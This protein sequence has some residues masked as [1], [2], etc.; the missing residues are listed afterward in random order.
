MEILF[1]EK[2]FRIGLGAVRFFCQS[3]GHQGDEASEAWP[4]GHPSGPPLELS[5]LKRWVQP[6]RRV[7]RGSNVFFGVITLIRMSISKSPITSSFVLV[8]K[9]PW[10]K[11][12]PTCLK[13]QGPNLLKMRR[14]LPR[15]RLYHLL[16]PHSP[17]SQEDLQYLLTQVAVRLLIRCLRLPQLR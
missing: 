7:A 17:L 11:D 14:S 15:Y 13:T 8:Y 3:R 1:R 6:Y 12:R 10:V 2:S 16:N 9:N 5:R 4:C